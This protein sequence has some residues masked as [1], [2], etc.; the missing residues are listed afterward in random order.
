MAEP[1]QYLHGYS[2]KEQERLRYQA[3]ILEPYVYDFIDL[4]NVNRLLEIGCGVGAQ[5]EILLKK[6]PKMH[7]T[8]VDISEKQLNAAKTHL[9]SQVKNNKVHFVQADATQMPLKNHAFDGA[10]ICW[11]LEHVPDPL[12][13]LKEAHKKLSKGA[14]IYCSEVQNAGVFV[15]PYSPAILKYWYQLNDQQWTDKGHPFIG[16]ELGHL[17]KQS[18]FKKIEHSTQVMLFDSRNPKQRKKFVSYFTDLMMSAAPQLLKNKRIDQNLLNEV[19]SEMSALAQN[20]N[21][22]IFFPFCRAKAFKL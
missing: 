7:I 5:T 19:K 6:F 21:S 2:K 18:G 15:E 22:V 11:F 13:V 10:F 16:A 20:K 9:K 8:G 12:A 17:L 3:K 4:K 1:I 14:V